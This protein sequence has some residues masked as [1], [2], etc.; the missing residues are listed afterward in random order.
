MEGVSVGGRGVGEEQLVA[1]GIEDAVAVEVTVDMD[2]IDAIAGGISHAAEI[3]SALPVTICVG[4]ENSENPPKVAGAGKSA[5]VPDYSSPA[6]V[7]DYPSRFSPS[8]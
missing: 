4:A 6:P 7:P 8:W 1:A 5:P 3:R 2:R